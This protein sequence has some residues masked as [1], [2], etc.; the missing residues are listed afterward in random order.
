MTSSSR[1]RRGPAAYMHVA[2]LIGVCLRRRRRCGFPLI[3]RPSYYNISVG[4]ITVDS[5]A[6][7]VEFTAVVDSG[8]SF[9]YLDDPAYTFL[10]T[11]VISRDSL[12]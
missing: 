7:A 1:D 10:T 6:M 12:S 3:C 8:T 5:K 2:D 9:T 4:A 11:N